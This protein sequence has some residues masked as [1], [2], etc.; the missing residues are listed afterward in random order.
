M[1]FETRSG[2]WVAGKVVLRAQKKKEGDQWIRSPREGE[3]EREW[4]YQ[5]AKRGIN[6]LHL[7]K[8]T[9]GIGSFYRKERNPFFPGG[10]V[11]GEP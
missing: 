10:E 9:G 5:K 8:S 4:N 1:R 11:S 6:R 3:G 2:K 7:I